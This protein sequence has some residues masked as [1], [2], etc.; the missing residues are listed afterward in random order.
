MYNSPSVK[1]DPEK[2]SGQFTSLKFEHTQTVL[3]PLFLRPTQFPSCNFLDP[4]NSPSTFF[5]LLTIS[6]KRYWEGN[7]PVLKYDG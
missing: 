6:L 5:R 3:L 2:V 4:D 1:L 7:C